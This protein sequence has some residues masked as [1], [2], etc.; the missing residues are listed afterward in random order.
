MSDK[1]ALNPYVMI[2]VKLLGIVSRDAIAVYCA[3]Y[4]NAK[5]GVVPFKAICKAAGL[6][7]AKVL[8]GM[9]ELHENRK[10]IV[11]QLDESLNAF[12]M[13]VEA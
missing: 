12:T 7:K 11:K 4:E 1:I 10:L 6:P 13:F 9:I 2:P 3:F 5:D 8:K